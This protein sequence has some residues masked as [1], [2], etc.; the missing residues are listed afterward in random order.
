MLSWVLHSFVAYMLLIHPHTLSRVAGRVEYG[1][2]Y[3]VLDRNTTFLKAIWPPIRETHK[4][5]TYVQP[6]A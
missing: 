3:L 1:A 5:M 4:D 6:N 2:R